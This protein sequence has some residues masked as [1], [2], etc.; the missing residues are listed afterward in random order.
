M[1]GSISNPNRWDSELNSLPCDRYNNAE[2]TIFL[3]VFLRQVNPAGGAAE[4]TAREWGTD[5][6]GTGSG[7]G[8]ARKIVRWTPNLWAQWTQRYQR[9]VQSFWHG[10]FWL[11][12]THPMAELDFEDKGVT[13]RPNIWCRFEL[14]VLDSAATAH[15]TISVVRLHPSEAF[16]RS[17]SADYDNRD[18]EYDRGDHGGRIYRQ[19][20][21]IHE[22]GHLLGL[23]HAAEGSAACT[24]AGNTGAEACYCATPDD[25]GN[26]MGAGEG[27]RAS[28]ASPW[29]KAIEAHGGG[30]ANLWEVKLRRHY[31]R[32]L[33]QVRTNQ[34]ITSWPRRG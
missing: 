10:K 18:I 2:L 9:E 16:F 7:H 21:H 17:D 23:D 33:D 11:V 28:N 6:A 32:T 13:Y 24:A 1:I 29:Q 22:V 25:C 15:T 20:A 14:D 34:Q 19:R 30:A 4:G 3:R 5:P 8:P 27:V 26:V 31:P 12:P